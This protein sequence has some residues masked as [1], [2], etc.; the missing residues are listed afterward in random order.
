MSIG[1]R[2]DDIS[3]LLENVVY[4]ELLRRGYT[5]YVGQQNDLEIDFIEI[6]ENEKRYFQVCIF[7]QAQKLFYPWIKRPLPAETVLSTVI[8]PSGLQH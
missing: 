6:R 7:Y 1:Y 2:A 3:G 8:Y 5:V 4:Q